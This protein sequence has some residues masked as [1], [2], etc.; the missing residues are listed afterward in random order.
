MSKNKLN[1]SQ[2][3]YSVKGLKEASLSSDVNRSI[4]GRFTS[5]KN[6]DILLKRGY[7]SIQTPILESTGINFE[8]GDLFFVGDRVIQT[9][10][11][12]WKGKILKIE[13]NRALVNWEK[14]SKDK[15]H[16]LCELYPLNE[17]GKRILP[18]GQPDIFRSARYGREMLSIKNI[19]AQ[20]LHQECI[21]LKLF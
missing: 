15:W 10:G 9:T 20:P 3:S 11:F 7:C 1:I 13:N 8:Q 17:L 21:Q 14:N 12:P 16:P 5:L 2:C 18:G 4:I 19:V 6:A